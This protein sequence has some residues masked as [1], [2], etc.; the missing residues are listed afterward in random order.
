MALVKPVGAL[1]ILAGAVSIG[2]TLCRERQNRL[3]TLRELLS[4]LE[5]L[6]GQLE[7][8]SP[9][10]PDLFAELADCAQGECCGFLRGIAEDLDQLGERSFYELW[11]RQVQRCLVSLPPTARDELIRL[12]TV[13]GRLDLE[14]ELRGLSACRKVL[15]GQLEQLRSQEPSRRRVILGL[16][17]A[18]GLVA[19]ILMI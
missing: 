14:A 18:T 9:P 5:Q 17:A 13:L 8:R 6:Q 15:G 3:R 1:L 19:V 11:R 4:A 2:L 7:L 12:G 16:S 10:L